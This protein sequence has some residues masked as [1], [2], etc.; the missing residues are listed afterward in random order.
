MSERRTEVVCDTTAY[1][2]ADLVAERGIHLIGL[3]VGLEGELEPEAE[4]TDYPQFFERLRASDSKVT[5]SQPSVGDFVS[6]YEPLL[7]A[8]K[9]VV[10]LHIAGGIS[11]T[12]EAAEQAASRL[13]EEG[14]G[15]ERIRVYDS[16]TSAGGLGLCALAACASAD[17][18]AGGE[19]GLERGGAAPAAPQIYFFLD[20]PG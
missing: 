5:T 17:S 8:G 19:A 4:I 10:S 13:A 16:H 7:A 1:L 18:G 14:K 9:D 15:G 11:G 3:D 20:T 6:V 12:C 2:P